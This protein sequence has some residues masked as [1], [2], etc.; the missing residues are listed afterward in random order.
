MRIFIAGATGVL[1]RALIP[2]LGRHGVVGLTRSREKVKLLESLG[3]DAL[4]G[5]AYDRDALVQTV[6]DAQP[7]IVVNFL[8]DLTDGVGEANIRMRREGGPNLLAA[9]Q[10][11]GARRFVVESVEFP[12]E[13]ASARA[14][15]SL[16]QDA[17]GSG[18]QALVVRFGRLWGPGTWYDQPPEPPR[19]HIEEAGRRAAELITE[20]S[21]GIHVV[22]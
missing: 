18:L 7:E 2:N 1:G 4:V 3:A 15:A 12:L 19:V 16:E 9:A 5:D 8:T 21:P 10:A 17:L 22:A 6:V 13:E 20:G 14:V 11:S